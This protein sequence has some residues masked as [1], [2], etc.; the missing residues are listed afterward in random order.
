MHSEKR[1]KSE[2]AVVAAP[3]EETAKLKRTATSNFQQKKVS[4]MF[5]DTVE[6]HVLQNISPVELKRQQVIHEIFTT[7]KQY[8]NDLKLTIRVGL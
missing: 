5:A 2:A 4:R 3:R 6:P 7:E 8:I 1:R